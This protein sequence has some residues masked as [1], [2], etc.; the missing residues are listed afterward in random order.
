[1]L[2]Y[3][4]VQLA[5]VILFTPVYAGGGIIEEKNRRTLEFLKASQLHSREIILGKFSARLA[6]VL[7]VLPALLIVALVVW[8]GS[9]LFKGWGGKGF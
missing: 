5:A 7:S 3:L 8:M 4:A 9:L 6:F 1:M 2:L